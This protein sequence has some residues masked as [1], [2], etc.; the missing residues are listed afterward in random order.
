MSHWCSLRPYLSFYR[1]MRCITVEGTHP[2][3][4]TLSPLQPLVLIRFLFHGYLIPHPPH[5]HFGRKK[6]VQKKFF[7]TW[8]I[9]RFQQ[10]CKEHTCCAVWISF[11]DHRLLTKSG[12]REIFISHS[13]PDNEFSSPFECICGMPE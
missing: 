9:C 12:G 2:L 7:H 11:S 10:A 5:T 3:Q 4:L 13:S 1:I 6:I 8:L